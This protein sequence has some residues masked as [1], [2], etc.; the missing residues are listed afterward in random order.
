[1]RSHHETFH[2][3][4]EFSKSQQ[5]RHPP[6]RFLR[7]RHWFSPAEVAVIINNDRQYCSLFAF[8]ENEFLFQ[9]SRVK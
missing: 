3:D 6:P 1:M 5:G 2:H 7:K 9:I 4:A 8:S